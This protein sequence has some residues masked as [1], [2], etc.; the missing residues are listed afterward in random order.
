M[1]KEVSQVTK[2]EVYGTNLMGSSIQKGRLFEGGGRLF[3]GMGRL[4]EGGGRLFE[5]GGRFIQG[6]M[7]NI[8]TTAKYHTFLKVP[9]V[10]LDT[11]LRTPRAKDIV[12]NK[13]RCTCLQIRML[14]QENPVAN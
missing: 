12:A 8:Y 5:G 10:F 13:Q 11:V 2:K 4:F 9:Q 3:E 6:N 14:F 1:L 7:A